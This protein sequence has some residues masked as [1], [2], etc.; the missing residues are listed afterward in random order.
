MLH[1]SKNDNTIYTNDRRSF[2]DSLV[3]GAAAL[4]T[5]AIAAPQPANAGIDPSLLRSYSVEGDD[6]GTAQRLRQIEDIQRP[7]SDTLN[8]PY[9]KLASGVEYREYREGKGDAVVGKGSKVAAEMTIR[10]KSFSTAKEPGGVK[11]Y[12]TKLDSDFNEIAWTVGEGELP[13]GLEEA[14]MG[15]H[16]NG[17]RRIEL[18]STQVFAAR[19]DNQLPVATTKDGKRVYDRL[20]KTDATLLFEVL[21]TRIK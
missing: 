17:V 12:S 4:T 9:E 6:S 21:V 2:V 5:I 11:Y 20:F 1:G 13:P 15:M 8:I 10:C 18:P 14:M 16:R 7:A 3:A 19:N